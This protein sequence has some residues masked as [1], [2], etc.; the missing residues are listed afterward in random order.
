MRTNPKSVERVMEGSTLNFLKLPGIANMYIRLWLIILFTKPARRFPYSASSI[1][2]GLTE[3]CSSLLGDVP[4]VLSPCLFVLSGSS[5]SIAIREVQKSPWTIIQFFSL[6][7]T[8]CLTPQCHQSNF[9][10]IAD[11][12]TRLDPTLPNHYSRNRLAG[13]LLIQHPISAES[14]PGLTECYPSLLAILRAFFH[15]VFHA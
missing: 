13:S 4:R 1:S 9:P 8:P 2:T 10:D 11:G 15:P 14:L 6:L 5:S 3:H 12:C 7:L